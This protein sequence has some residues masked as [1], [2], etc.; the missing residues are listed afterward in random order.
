[1][2][3]HK[4]KIKDKVLLETTIKEVRIEDYSKLLR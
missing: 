1:M 2:I 4:Y 3:Q